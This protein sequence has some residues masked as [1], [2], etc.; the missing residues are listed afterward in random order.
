MKLKLIV[1]LTLCMSPFL[2]SQD[3]NGIPVPANAG[4]GKIWKIQPQSDDFNYT[5]EASTN[6]ATIGGK[7][8]NFYHN[9]WDGPGP[10]KWRYENTTVSGGN[11]HV[12]ATRQANETKTFTVDCDGDNVAESWTMAATRAGCITSKTRVKYPVYVEARFKI[13]NAV[14]A[15]DIWMLSPDDTQ[16]IDILEAYG[17]KATRN[18]WLAQ[19]LHLS[20][21]VFIRSPFLDYQPTDASTWYTGATKTY[22]TDKW[23]RLGVYWA[24]PTRLEYY[25]DGQLVKVMDN[26]DTVNGKDGIDPLNYTSTATPRTA[27]TRTGLVKEMDIIINMEDQN[28][29]ACKGRTPTDEE[30]TNFD[31]HN[32][33]IDWIR[34]YKPVTDPNLGKQDA[35]IEEKKLMLFPN[36]FKD[37]IQIN[38]EK[39]ISTVQIY[40]LSG[41]KLLVEKINNTNA[42]IA[43]K[44]LSA[45]MYIA[46]I[47][48]E[49][50]TTISQKVIKQ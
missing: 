24:S 9:T 50:G 26:L 12:F 48:W 23:I 31:N 35:K 21:H 14:M 17:G 36:P 27:A 3:W 10:T 25:L 38:S 4:T 20:H 29:N 6:Q 28:W 46:K 13:A 2:Y 32:F 42:T 39:N 7:W 1:L 11:L 44:N 43:T 30:I 34:I 45:G 40:S 18:D 37:S 47:N 33:N 16:E 15:S 22:W 8:T 49:D 19:R 41:T 5:Y